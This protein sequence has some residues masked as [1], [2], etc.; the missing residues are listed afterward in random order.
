MPKTTKVKLKLSEFEKKPSKMS[1]VGAEEIFNY[2]VLEEKWYEPLLSEEDTPDDPSE[3]APNFFNKKGRWVI[4][5]PAGSEELDKA[6]KQVEKGIREGV[7]FEANFT[8]LDGNEPQSINIF[9]YD[10]IDKEDVHFVH[11]EIVDRKIMEG[12]FNEGKLEYFAQ[13]D[14]NNAKKTENWQDV[15]PRYTSE[16]LKKSDFAQTAVAREQAFIDAL[17]QYIND[18]KAKQQK[19]S[20]IH[21]FFAWAGLTT[22][23]E[24][25][26]DSANDMRKAIKGDKSV[27]F[28]HDKIR[29]LTQGNLGDVIKQ[30]DDVLLK[31]FQEAMKK[32][33]LNLSKP[34]W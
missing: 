2:A 33:A 19:D 27:L 34:R 30:F 32:D 20:S 28:N 3:S 13:R 16:S 11:Q 22:S 23:A 24:Y 6:W 14:L 12:A 7:F 31:E 10:Y 1:G 5:F 21:K 29:A 18:R 17:D 26:I 25:K 4:K 9:T 8:R 15:S